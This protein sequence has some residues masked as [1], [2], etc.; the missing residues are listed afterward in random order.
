M[1]IKLKAIKECKSQRNKS[2]MDR[3]NIL[4]L[5]CT[6]GSQL[7]KDYTG[8]FEFVRSIIEQFLKR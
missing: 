7:N 8:A 2:Y 5:G 6:C 4:A 1:E 3:I